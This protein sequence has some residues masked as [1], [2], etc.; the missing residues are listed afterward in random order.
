[1]L[2]A[3]FT[4][5]GLT[6]IASGETLQINAQSSNPFVGAIAPVAGTDYTLVSGIVT[7]TLSSTSGASTV[8][9]VLATS[10]PAVI[11]DLQVR[12]YAVNTVNTVQVVAEDPTSIATYGRKS[13]PDAR[14]PK[15]PSLGDAKAIGTVILAQRS[16]RLPTISVSIQAA[17]TIELTQQLTRNLSDRVHVVEPHTGLDADCFVEQISHSIAQGGLEHSTAFGLEKAATQITGALILGSA[18]QGVLGTNRL[19][20]RGLTNPLT[21]FVLGSGSNGVLGANILTP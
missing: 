12:A 21:M 16:D 7:I 5:Q 8:I 13:L 6:T 1:V 2:S 10:G 3:V 4:S 20:R 18:T 15:W 9:S 11:A 19:G 14:D 17:N